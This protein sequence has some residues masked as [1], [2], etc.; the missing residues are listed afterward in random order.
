VKA[1]P[2][3]L[4][5]ILET[6]PKRKL[7]IN[8]SGTEKGLRGGLEEFRNSL[9]TASFGRLEKKGLKRLGEEQRTGKKFL[10]A[11]LDC[12]KTEKVMTKSSE[13][14]GGGVGGWGEEETKG[15]KGQKGNL[16]A[17]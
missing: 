10:H 5:S 15:V 1:P 7:L 14:G 17:Y 3:L 6:C 2:F 16:L 9:Y 4:S 13:P 11:G 12:D 8:S